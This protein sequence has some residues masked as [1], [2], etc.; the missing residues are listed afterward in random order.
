MELM[1]DAVASQLR[2]SVNPSSLMDEAELM[3]DLRVYSVEKGVIEVPHRKTD[4]YYESLL[5]LNVATLVG[6]PHP[7]WSEQESA[8][9]RWVGESLVISS[10]LSASRAC[11]S[12][13]NLSY[14]ASG[15]AGSSSA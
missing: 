4:L 13:I 15:I 10:G 14:S 11:N 1:Q 9:T 6:D 3:A 2:I 5:R 12:R 8:P 7:P